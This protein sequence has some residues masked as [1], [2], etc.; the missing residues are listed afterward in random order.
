MKRPDKTAADQR[1]ANRGNVP[2]FLGMAEMAMLTTPAVGQCD[3]CKR[4]TWE[5][6][7]IGRWCGMTQ[8]GGRCQGTFRVMQ[9]NAATAAGE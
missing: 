6:L 4:P 8:A 2:G 5:P 3:T 7:L 1:R 9:T